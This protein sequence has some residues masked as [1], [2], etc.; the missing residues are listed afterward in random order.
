MYGTKVHR[1]GKPGG[2]TRMWT[3]YGTDEE[4]KKP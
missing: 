4:E 2:S 1:R 3:S